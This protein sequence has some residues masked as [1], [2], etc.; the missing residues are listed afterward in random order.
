VA[1]AMICLTCGQDASKAPNHVSEEN[2]AAIINGHGVVLG[3]MQ[4]RLLSILLTSAPN[5]VST[6]RLIEL[7]YG[8]RE[9]EYAEGSIKVA[10][11]RLRTKL[12]GAAIQNTHGAGYRLVAR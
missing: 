4:A 12:Q 10:I 8:D 9:P 2:L 3:H 11:H 7:I 1:V 5:F 6:G